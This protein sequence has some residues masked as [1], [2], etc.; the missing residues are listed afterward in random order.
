M[1]LENSTIDVAGEFAGIGGPDSGSDIPDA[2]YHGTTR[3]NWAMLRDET[4]LY[5]TEDKE[6]ARQYA[7]DWGDGV[8]DSDEQI[9]VAIP[10]RALAALPGITLEP[11]FENV[12]QYD[13]GAWP[14]QPGKRGA[15]LTWKD[16]LAMSGTFCIRGFKEEHKGSAVIESA[17]LQRKVKLGG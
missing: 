2:L 3:N 11:N 5:V 4:A 7:Q 6:V 12:E 17:R 1:E 15:D 16:T 13:D 8:G 10:V 14:R 9:V